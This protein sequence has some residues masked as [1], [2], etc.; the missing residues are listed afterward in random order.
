MKT[1]LVLLGLSLAANVAVAVASFL[2]PAAAP[3]ALRDWFD[4]EGAAARAAETRQRESRLA[5][6]RAAA[7]TKRAATAQARLWSTLHA[8][9]LKTLVD[10]L[11]T[12]GFPP[13]LI[14]AIVSAEIE[15]RF[16][17]RM[18]AL[19]STVIDTPYWRPAP[20]SSFYNPKFHEERQQIYRERAKLMR[21]LLGHDFYASYYTSD[22]TVAQ[23]RQFGDLPQGK[24][25]LIQRINDDYA[26]MTAQV[27]AASQGITLPEDRD[28]LAL[29][30]RE[31]RADLAALLTPQEL[32][33]YEMRSS[34]NAMR[35]RTPMTYMNASEDEYR[36]IFRIQ[37]KYADIL[38]PPSAGGL[39]FTSDTFQQRRDATDQMNAEIARALGP[40][41]GADFERASSSEF[42]Q[43]AEIV[44]RDGRSLNDAI[45][46]YEVR[47]AASKE[48]QRIGDDASLS[49]E[50]KRAALLTL[51][52][53]TRVQLESALGPTSGAA[54]TK[55]S[56][57]LRAL[58]N[59]Q[60]VSFSGSSTSFRPVS[61]TPPPPRN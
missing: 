38:Y 11:R 25:D 16:S 4:R 45:R 61:S 49:A 28:K 12:G 13:H 52:Q 31:K 27:R 60:I 22:P 29:L 40:A 1:L 51:A 36:A 9:D 24:I 35:L 54:Y 48:S 39:S 33:D 44:Q 58:E 41:R 14:R 37:Q 5:A 3:S 53:N 50:Q 32:E 23:R 10:R 15:Q 6:A 20:T 55:S 2:R 34:Q 26:E 57:W 7:E 19:M 30:E 21:D 56:S 47:D 17:G 18:N 42:R 46:A 43:M 8:S 59:G